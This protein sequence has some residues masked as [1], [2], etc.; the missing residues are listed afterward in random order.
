MEQC[1]LCKCTDKPLKESHIIPKMF[2]NALKRNSPTCIMRM[3]DDPNR[4]V[5]DGLKLPFQCGECEE[6]FSKY[7]RAFSNR[8]Y[9]KA[10][11]NDGEIKFES[12]D[13]ALSYFLLSV[14]WRV[15]KHTRET[16]KTTLTECELEKMDG[17]I[18]TWRR[19]LYDENMEEIRKVQ[20]FIIP[21]K[22]LR[23]FENIPFRVHDNVMIDFKTFDEE[24]TFNFAFT[25]V[26]VPYFIFITTVWGNTD[27]MKQYQLGK[28]I[29]P[30]RSTLPKNI[31]KCL[32]DLHFK[33]YFEANDKLAEKQRKL[34][35]ERVEKAQK[36]K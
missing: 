3:A 13:D 22:N 2:Y 21:T 6:L 26:Q 7:E 17:I 11:A 8:I 16:D 15:I 28:A 10:I 33:K 9:Q 5:Q 18:E 20:Q 34:I 36:H 27:T 24:N 32:E 19:I 23:F 1:R 29:K 31:T 30:Y 4:G 14:A 35:E 12:K 25:I